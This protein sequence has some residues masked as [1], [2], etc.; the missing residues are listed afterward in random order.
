MHGFGA[1]HALTELQ[2]IDHEALFRVQ[3]AIVDVIVDVDGQL[4]FLDLV[5]GESPRIGRDRAELHALE[6][7]FHVGEERGG[8]QIDLPADARRGVAIHLAVERDFGAGLRIRGQAHDRS[9]EAL[10]ADGV[11][12]LDPEV[13]EVRRTVRD[14][15]RTDAEA[16]AARIPRRRAG[17]ALRRLHGLN[18]RR[19]G[20]G[21]GTHRLDHVEGLIRRDDHA[22]IRSACREC[23]DAQPL[24]LGV[25]TQA[26]RLEL[27]PFDEILAQGVVHRA[28]LQHFGVAF[29]VEHALLITLDVQPRF[30]Y[31]AQQGDLRVG[32]D[33]RLECLEIEVIDVDMRGHRARVGRD[34]RTGLQFSRLVDANVRVD[35]ECRIR[36]SAV[37]VHV[38]V[39]GRE[40]EGRAGLQH[41]I[42]ELESQVLDRNV[43]SSEDPARRRRG[44][45]G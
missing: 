32:V 2:L 20:A 13:R 37:A 25:V 45:S 6:A 22:R 44:R 4:S 36:C 15:D 30:Q 38:Q 42:F 43:W 26:L 28:Q 8:E 21:C 41:A 7:H 12:R 34:V 16:H 5:A 9:V 27:I 35:V 23:R 29:D 11:V 33:V 39:D 18:G 19:R 14:P 10:Q 24:R 3:L 31:A 1:L 17:L 40:C